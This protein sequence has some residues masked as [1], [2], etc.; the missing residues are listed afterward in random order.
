MPTNSIIYDWLT[1]TS[2]IDSPSSVIDLLGLSCVKF[3]LLKGRYSY[4]DRLSFGDINIYFNGREDMGIC[5]EMSGQGCRDFETYG[6]GDYDSIF[7]T[8]IDGYSEESAS[9]EYNITRLDVAYND[10]EKV[11]DLPLLV[12]ECQLLHWV[13]PF[14]KWK[15][16]VG[17]EGCS[18]EHGDTRSGNCSIR[19]YDKYMEQINKKGV[20]KNSLDFNSWV[21]CE[22]QLRRE[23][24]LGFIKL[25]NPIEKN[26]FDVLNYYLRY[27]VPTENITNNRV[28]DTAPFWLRF[29]RS[30]DRKSI[31]CKPGKTYNFGK[32]HSYVTTQCSA[33]IDTFIK[34][35][36]VDQFLSDIRNSRKGKVLNPKYSQL[37]QDAEA[38]QHGAELLA[39]IGE[40]EKLD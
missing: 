17:S 7:Q 15:V 24:A 23:C 29:I 10:F 31:F 12:R 22:I 5:V 20:D 19:I 11:L 37:L 8:I 38:H 3:E 40:E 18:V 6:N 4:K 1:F 9:R 21:R 34:I 14:H 16:I 27:I 33:A 28:L 2:K 36:G 35:V 25:K 26:Y 30:A 32:L 13:S 39:A